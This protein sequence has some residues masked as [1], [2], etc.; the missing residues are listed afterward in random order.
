MQP[1]VDIRTVSPDLF[2]YSLAAAAAPGRHCGDFFETAERCLLDAGRGLASYFDSVQIRF[3]GFF[4]GSYPVAR[5]VDDP[6]GLFEELMAR[7]VAVYGLRSAPQRRG[8][9]ALRERP[10]SA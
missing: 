9:Q 4:L 7:V 1:I 5:L 6:L 8:V 2:T 3:A 10:S